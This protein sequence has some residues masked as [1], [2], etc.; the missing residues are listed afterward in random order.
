M[1]KRNGYKSWQYYLENT[2]TDSID[3]YKYSK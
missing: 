2:P 3:N 1:I